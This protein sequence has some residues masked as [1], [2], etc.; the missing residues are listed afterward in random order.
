V[1]IAYEDD[2][3]VVLLDYSTNYY[4]LFL[5]EFAGFNRI[6]GTEYYYPKG[7]GPTSGVPFVGHRIKSGAAAAGA[8]AP[9]TGKALAASSAGDA[10]EER[11]I[12]AKAA[13]FAGMNATGHASPAVQAAA[14]RLEAALAATR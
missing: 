5:F 8:D 3:W 1:A 2:G 14:R 7:E 12:A 10:L 11:L 9:G 13:Y 6:E 4:D